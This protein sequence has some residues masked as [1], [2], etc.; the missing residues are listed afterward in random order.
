MPKMTLLEM[1][2]N[3]LSVMEDDEVNSIS[4]TPS[5]YSVAQ[6]IR[7]CYY[8][9]VDELDLPGNMRLQP[10]EAVSDVDRPN[11]LKLPD[12][13]IKLHWFKYNNENLTYLTPFEF[14]EFINKRTEGLDVT[15]F[16]GVTYRISE[17]DDPKYWT[18]FDDVYIV[19]DSF[20]NAVDS[21]LQHSKSVALV[22]VESDFDMEDNAI[23]DLPTRLFSTLLAKSKSRCFVSFKQVAN[24]KED[25]AE[26]RGLV[27][28]Q[29]DRFRANGVQAI[30]RLPNYARPR[31]ASR[32]GSSKSAN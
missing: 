19:T 8:E 29:N 14:M 30:D 18:T 16:N 4:D 28:H 1:T 6:V 15:D 23:P 31:A 20:N 25:E 11:Y 3:I 24:V 9:L 22:Q 5:S 17:T 27:R 7:D 26:R 21:T 13:L 2:Q 12:H 10:L 32:L